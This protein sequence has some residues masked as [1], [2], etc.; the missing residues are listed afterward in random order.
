MDERVL[1]EIVARIL[2][3][4]PAERIILFGSA[5]RGEDGPDSDL[6][7]LV[8]AACDHRRMTAQRV[9]RA[10]AGIGRAKDVLVVKPEDVG[11]LRESPAGVYAEAFRDGRTLYAA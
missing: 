9:Y 2:R 1:S 4:V 11:M 5:A 10:L 3:V 8:I 7:L 6:D